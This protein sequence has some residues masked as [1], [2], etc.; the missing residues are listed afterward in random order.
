MSLLVLGGLGAAIG[1]AILVALFYMLLSDRD[2][3]A[4]DRRE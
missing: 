3:D 2:G 4:R 1:L